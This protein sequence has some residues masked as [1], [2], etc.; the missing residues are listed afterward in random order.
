MKKKITVVLSVVCALCLFLLTACGEREPENPVKDGKV[1]LDTSQL[2]LDFFDSHVLTATLTDTE[3]ITW[4]TSNDSIAAVDTNGKI[5]AGHTAGQAT[6]TAKSGNASA[7]CSVTVKSKTIPI[8]SISQSTLKLAEQSTYEISLDVKY[9]QHDIKGYADFGFEISDGANEGVASKEN[10][11]DNIVKLKALSEGKTKFVASASVLGYYYVEY[12]DVE[13]VD[14]GVLFVAEGL[15]Y[16]TNGYVMEL[17]RYEAYDNHSY[18]TAKI[19]VY[20]GATEVTDAV[21]NWSIDDESIVANDNGIF[22]PLADGQTT[23]IGAYEGSLIRIT[24]NVSRPVFSLNDTFTI[25][26]AAV[27]A[28]DLSNINYEG[29]VTN[30]TIEG[31]SVMVENGYDSVAD[32]VLLDGTLLPNT[33][34]TMG[35]RTAVLETSQARYAF[36]LDLY[37]RILR[38]PSDFAHINS[39]SYLGGGVWDGYFILANDIEYDGWQDVSTDSI[40]AAKA[41]FNDDGLSSEI[42]L[43]G[44]EYG[45][46]GVFDGRGYSINGYVSSRNENSFFGHLVNQDGVIKNI[47]FTNVSF[48]ETTVNMWRSI[49]TYAMHGT[50]ENVYVSFKANTTISEFEQGGTLCGNWN[51]GASSVAIINCFIDASNVSVNNANYHLVAKL[52]GGAIK[53]T[54]LICVQ[55]SDC[56]KYYVRY[57]DIYDNYEELAENINQESWENDFWTIKNGIPCP[58]KLA[59]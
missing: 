54:N 18:D 8:F 21:I 3:G 45:F 30:V 10:V 34:K 53:L 15:G 9:N 24:A 49:I 43:N 51:A 1:T 27:D 44:N 17:S 26:T 35:I 38:S 28:I 47:S 6:I 16:D 22:K 55:S 31:K 37:T 59:G 7:S 32:T 29:N 25:E 52:P 40:I 42:S 20:D 57:G 4:E 13:V 5:T 48:K 46:R 50:M 39:E 23:I 41:T 19:K 36:T 14:L 56:I 33:C 2:S 58:K 11:A 12:L